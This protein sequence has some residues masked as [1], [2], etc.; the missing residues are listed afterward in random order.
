MKRKIQK[1]YWE[2]TRAEKIAEHE[3]AIE[4]LSHPHNLNMATGYQAA[5]N[6]RDAI[7]R[8]QESLDALLKTK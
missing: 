2:K 7:R 6:C 4:R 8:H 1:P 3:G 5:L